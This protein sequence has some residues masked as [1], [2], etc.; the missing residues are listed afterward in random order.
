[1]ATMPTPAPGKMELNMGEQIVTDHI[2]DEA[3][4]TAKIA[5]DAVTA[6][7]ADTFF[8]DEITGVGSDSPEVH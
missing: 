1:M 8:S 4:S 5:D 7:K 2:V 3:V 6:A